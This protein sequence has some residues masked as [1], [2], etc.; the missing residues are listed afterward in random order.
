M[1]RIAGIPSID[2]MIGGWQLYLDPTSAQDPVPGF[3]RIGHLSVV[4][5]KA[6]I[7]GS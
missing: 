5:S 2:L 7:A 6:A 4:K 3:L 1:I